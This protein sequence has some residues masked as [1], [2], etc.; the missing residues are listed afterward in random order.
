MNGT[1]SFIANP[2]PELLIAEI[3]QEWSYKAQ[4]PEEGLGHRFQ[5]ERKSPSGPTKVYVGHDLATFG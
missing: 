5:D 4:K 2:G 1:T 3:E